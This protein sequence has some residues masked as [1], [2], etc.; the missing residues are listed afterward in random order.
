MKIISQ[1][2]LKELLRYIPET[3]QFF[4]TKTGRKFYVDREAGS[5]RSN[6]RISIRIDNVRFEAHR[7]AFLYIHGY[8][9]AMVDHIN[10][11]VSDNRI[12]NLRACDN[13]K[14]QHNRKVSGRNAV[15]LKGVQFANR[16]GHKPLF[17]SKITV[18]GKP[19]Y[20]GYFQT[21]EEAHE[22]YWAKA[23]EYFGEFAR[24]N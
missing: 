3:G 17:R 1:E 2:R 22:A 8:M 7:L 12:E 23:Q 11:N 15:G 18:N 10:G 6:G 14:N 16:P 9:P 19:I 21:A 5:K 20:L 13:R 4:G 24:K